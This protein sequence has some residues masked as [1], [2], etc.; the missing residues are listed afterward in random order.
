MPVKVNDTMP[1]GNVNLASVSGVK[2]RTGMIE[3]TTKKMMDTTDNE[4]LNVSDHHNHHNPIQIKQHNQQSNTNGKQEKVI[5][6]PYPKHEQVKVQEK[7]VLGGQGQSI[8]YNNTATSQ[9]FN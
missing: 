6:L 5:D 2:K 7:M 3:T 8:T 1:I 4:C 9:A